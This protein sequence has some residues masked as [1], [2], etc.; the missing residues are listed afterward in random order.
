MD[1]VKTGRAYRHTLQDGI[2]A[3]DSKVIDVRAGTEGVVN[4]PGVFMG[5]KTEALT[6]HIYIERDSVEPGGNLP[7]VRR[8]STTRNGGRQTRKRP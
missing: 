1:E 2:L 7:S 6:A 3:F 4:F 8:K 5:E